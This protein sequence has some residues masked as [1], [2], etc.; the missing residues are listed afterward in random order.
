MSVYKPIARKSDIVMQE[1]D[2][3]TLIYDI[4]E[5]KAFNLNHT[6]AMVWSLCNGARTVADIAKDMTGKL[7]SVITEDFVWLAVEQLKKDNLLEDC[8]AIVIP[9]E[10][11]SRRK[12]IRK[13]GLASLVAF[14]IISSLLAPLPIHAASGCFGNNNAR[15]SADGCTC[16]S[17]SDCIGNCCADSPN[18]RVCISTNRAQGD[19]CGNNCECSLDCCVNSVCAN[20]TVAQGGAC[21]RSCQCAT[22]SLTC[23]GGRCCPTGG[24]P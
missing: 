4:I 20:R 22:T 2:D 1:I 8:T 24:C 14:P 19:P 9:F 10:G 18:P 12:I 6:S 7:D 3:E 13:V 11:L 16:D 17:A 21:T 15:Q 5:N 23:Q